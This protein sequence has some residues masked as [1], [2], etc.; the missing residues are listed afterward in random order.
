[1]GV[2]IEDGEYIFR[3]PLCGSTN[4][5]EEVPHIREVYFIDDEYIGCDCCD[6]EPKHMDVDD[7][8]VQLYEENRLYDQE[9]RYSEYV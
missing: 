4:R 9:E 6:S 5:Y 8:A 3:C 2:R 1:M 7:Y